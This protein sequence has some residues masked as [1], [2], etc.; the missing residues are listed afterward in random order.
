MHDEIERLLVEAGMDP[1]ARRCQEMVNE[2]KE[3]MIR[4]KWAGFA[5]CIVEVD[6]EHTGVFGFMRVGGESS[7][8]MNQAGVEGVVMDMQARAIDQI[9]RMVSDE[10]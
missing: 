9:A 8:C 1:D 10:G 3:I 5:R 7:E 4:R 6:P 2:M